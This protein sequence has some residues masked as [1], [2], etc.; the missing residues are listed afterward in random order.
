[1]SRYSVDP[2]VGNLEKVWHNFACRN[3]HEGSKCAYKS[4]ALE[5]GI[6]NDNF[7]NWLGFNLKAKEELTT[8]M[9]EPCGKEVHTTMDVDAK[10]V[11][12][13]LTR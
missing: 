9:S 7:Y 11:G 10:N 3:L 5:Q 6:S 4:G 13:L 12:D 1:M 8:N 2:W